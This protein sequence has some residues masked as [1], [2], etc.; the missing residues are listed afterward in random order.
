[1]C[2][3]ADFDGEVVLGT[4]N[5]MF[6]DFRTDASGVDH[7]FQVVFAFKLHTGCFTGN[8]KNSCNNTL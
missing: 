8:G 3:V 4:K 5:Q 1:M 6:V 7:G 2:A